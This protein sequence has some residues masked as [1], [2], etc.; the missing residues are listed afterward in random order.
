MNR[1]SMG[2]L[3][4]DLSMVTQ[5]PGGREMLA[6][7]AAEEMGPEKSKTLRL[8]C[9]GEAKYANGGLA[10]AAEEVRA[11]G[12]GDDEILLHVSPEEYEALVAMW[13]EPEINPQ[14]GLPEYGFLSKLWKKVKKGVKRIVKNP[15]FSL[16]APVALNVLAPGLGSAIGGALGASGKVASTIGNTLL[17][18]GIGAASGGKEGALSG[19]ASGLTMG[20]AGQALGSKLGLSGNVAKYA[21][22]AIIGGGTSKLAGGDFGQGALGQ[23]QTSFLQPKIE[24]AIEGGMRSLLG[25]TAGTG[26]EFPNPYTTEGEMSTGGVE[27]DLWGNQNPILES[28]SIPQVSGGGGGGGFDI[29]S[30]FS[31]AGRWIKENPLLAASG[32][33]LLASGSGGGSGGGARPP[34]LPDEFTQSLPAYSFSR[35]QVPMDPQAYYTYGQTGGEHSF[36][37]PNAIGGPA[38]GPGPN[39]GNQPRFDPGLLP[40]LLPALTQ[41]AGANFARGG[42]AGYARGAGSGRDDTIEALLSDGEFV[43]DAETVSLLG[44]GSNEE[45]AR[46]LEELRQKLR[47]HKGKG[48]ARG[49]FSPDA[50]R[51][52]EYISNLRK[53][54]GAQFTEKEAEQMRQHPEENISNLRKKLGAQFT[55]K[56]AQQLQRRM[57]RKRGGKVRKKAFIR[58]LERKYGE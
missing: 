12:R 19:I 44:D 58:S 27:T 11:G 47:K 18:G 5:V 25:K 48:L 21:G 10:T 15:L 9:G 35:S 42:Y 29:G 46:R 56:E 55:E 39:I 37:D 23:L 57:R 7:I 50:K 31:K 45:G 1:G 30:M 49:K 43:M 14:T 22:D 41:A 17:R 36:F 6:T 51:P 33:A 16:I 54:L 28:S 4:N 13:G 3:M 26:G 2:Q 32:A 52:E 24:S 20:G 53:T 38:P 8:Y 34:A 40:Q